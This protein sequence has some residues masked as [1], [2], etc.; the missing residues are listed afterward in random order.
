MTCNLLLINTT[1][2]NINSDSHVR[3]ESD[4]GYVKI[5]AFIYF[6]KLKFKNH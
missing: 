5:E 3:S 4:L 1:L 6:F 2:D